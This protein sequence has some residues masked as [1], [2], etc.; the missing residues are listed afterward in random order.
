[1]GMDYEPG[2]THPQQFDLAT[3][4]DLSNYRHDMY[5]WGPNGSPG[6]GYAITTP[7]A[8]SVRLNDGITVKGGT[9]VYSLSYLFSV[10]GKLTDSDPTFD[11]GFCASLS[12][13]TGKGT[14]TGFCDT[15][16]QPF[17]S[18][19]T[20]TYADLPFGGPVDPTLY[21]VA[22]VLPPIIYPADVGTLG[23]TTFGGSASANFGSTI[24][25]E[26][27]LVTDSNGKPIPGVK[28][29]STGGYN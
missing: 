29:T 25:L 3:S 27:L 9:G 19:F 13:P 5:V 1:M 11:A 23:A 12:I 4:I 28:I 20:L 17:R 15:V 26:S 2:R 10:D 6:N 24:T 21:L 7:G 22:Y 14:V 16:N 8:S 18:T